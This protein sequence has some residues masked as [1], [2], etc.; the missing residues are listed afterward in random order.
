MMNKGFSQGEDDELDH[1][2]YEES[3]FCPDCGAS[4]EVDLDHLTEYEYGVA[5]Q[6]SCPKCHL[7]FRHFERNSWGPDERPNLVVVE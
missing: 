4:C 6:V 5:Y 1:Q 3:G 2:D 7:S